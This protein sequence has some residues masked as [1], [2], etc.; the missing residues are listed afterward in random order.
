MNAPAHP[1]S[2][3]P[4]FFGKVRTH[5]DFVA[6]RLPAAF[7]APWDRCMQEG[8]V[9]ARAWFGEQWL[10]VYLSMP[11]WCFALGRGTCGESA[12]AGVLMPGVDRIGRYF[13]FTIAAPVE[14]ER[15]AHWLDGAQSWYDV[16]GELALSTLRPDFSLKDF[17]ARV[18][19]SDPMSAAPLGWRLSAIGQDDEASGRPLAE[20]LAAGAGPG[21]GAFW[22]EGSDA[23][24]ASLRSDAGLPDGARFTSMLDPGPATWRSVV[25]LRF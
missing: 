20:L 24:P 22:T 21:C 2:A 12:W 3:E 15:L 19:T 14:P 5:G 9:F 17:D 8:M 4:G 11:V 25:S 6:R 16:A 10:P 7:I 1:A 23:C 13:P 18:R